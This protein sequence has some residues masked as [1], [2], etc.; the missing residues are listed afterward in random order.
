MSRQLGTP[1]CRLRAVPVTSW[2]VDPAPVSVARF[3]YRHTSPEWPPLVHSAGEPRPSQESGRWHKHGEGYAQYLAESPAGA[4]AE[5]VRYYEIRSSAFAAEQRRNLWLIYVEEHEIAD[6]STFDAWV[7][8]GLDPS[9]AVG[10]H[11]PCQDLAFELEAQG[12]RGVLSPSAALADTINLTLFGSRYEHV[13]NSDPRGWVNPDP[14]TWLA[15]QLAAATA[16][17]PA[18]LLTQTCFLGAPHLGYE[19]WKA[20]KDGA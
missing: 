6:L 12:Y 14:H 15:C 8:C 9:L 17:P 18:D 4:W 20:P 7:R 5:L 2:A 3:W 10:K 13:L 19:V 11:A 16:A 1:S